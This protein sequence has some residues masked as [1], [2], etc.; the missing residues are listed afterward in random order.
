MVFGDDDAPAHRHQVND[1]KFTKGTEGVNL[2]L[3][4]TLPP[5]LGLSVLAVIAFAARRSPRSTS[6]RARRAF[7]YVLIAVPLPLAVGLHLFLWPA[8]ALDRIAFVVGVIAFGTGALLVLSGEEEDDR[9]ELPDDPNPA[10]WWP[11]FEREFREYEQT[12]RAASR[13][14]TP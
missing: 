7:G 14:P 4:S 1:G 5:L 6:S 10:P 3:L 8:S 9:W 12:T 11:D 2:G 13:V